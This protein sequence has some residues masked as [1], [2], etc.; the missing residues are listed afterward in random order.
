[1]IQDGF[2]LIPEKRD[3]Y[4]EWLEDELVSGRLGALYESGHLFVEGDL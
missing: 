4:L 3:R 1:M 2:V